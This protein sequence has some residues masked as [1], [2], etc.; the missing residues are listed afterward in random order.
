MSAGGM[1]SWVS[2]F[3]LFILLLFSG[4][5]QTLTYLPRQTAS[6]ETNP[7]GFPASNTQGMDG[8]GPQSWFI[9]MT[10]SVAVPVHIRRGRCENESLFQGISDSMWNTLP[11]DHMITTTQALL[12]LQIP[13]CRPFKALPKYIHGLQSHVPA[14]DADYLIATG[15]L[16]LPDEN[17][18]CELLRA[19]MQFVYPYVPLL[20]TDDI[21]QAISDN[22][23][24]NPISILLYQAM[25]FSALPFVDQQHFRNARY[26]SAKA[27]RYQ[28]YRRVKVSASPLEIEVSRAIHRHEK[29][30]DGCQLLYVFN[31]ELDHITLIQSLILMTYWNE[32]PEDSNNSRDW[33]E[34][35]LSHSVA[36]KLHH[37]FDPPGTTTKQGRLQRRLWWCLYTRDRLMALN[38][39]QPLLIED[40]AYSV[41]MVTEHDFDF[42][43]TE[44]EVTGPGHQPVAIRSTQLQRRQRL[45]FIEKV[46]LCLVLSEIVKLAISNTDLHSDSRSKSN[47][48]RSCVKRLGEWHS[49]L[50]PE[51]QYQPPA[52]H[53]TVDPLLTPCAWLKLVFTAYRVLHEQTHLTWRDGRNNEKVRLAIEQIALIAEDLDRLNQTRTLPSSSVGILLPVLPILMTDIQRASSEACAVS[54]RFFYRCM[55]VL[56]TL[57]ETYMLAEVTASFFQSVLAKGQLDAAALSTIPP[58]LSRI[59]DLP[60]VMVFIN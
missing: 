14:A 7:P 20:D 54:F 34:D 5:I 46:K 49:R 56:E 19:F 57:G 52:S 50:S 59:L 29:P 26:L 23:G 35:A 15:A 1:C 40:G 42:I 31:T 10:E 17:L 22:D 27:A 43:P 2:T 12:G 13:G 24:R 11:L 38:L 45:I 41:S 18:S 25:M 37:D 28:F 36:I 39:R 3:R 48:L 51:I 47:S 55:K 8:R 33:L 32:D 4:V 6:H 30:A 21:F 44:A 9:L 53:A 16:L 60:R 58:S